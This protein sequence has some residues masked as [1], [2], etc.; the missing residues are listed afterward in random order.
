MAAKICS[1]C[2]KR[3]HE[4]RKMVA[5]PRNLNVVPP[6]ICDECIRM[7]M[8][9]VNENS[10]RFRIDYVIRELTDIKNKLPEKT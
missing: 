8:I 5:A 9:A 10:P 7:C 2:G 1:F 6:V 3:P 4:V